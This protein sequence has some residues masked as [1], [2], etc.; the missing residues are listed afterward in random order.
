MGVMFLVFFPLPYLDA[1]SLPELLGLRILP[2]DSISRVRERVARLG[3][4]RLL[5]HLGSESLEPANATVIGELLEAGRADLLRDAACGALG[6]PGLDGQTALVVQA[7]NAL[8][9]VLAVACATAQTA[10]VV[11]RA[12][13]QVRHLRS[14]TSPL[15]LERAV[16]LQI[17]LRAGSFLR[18]PLPTV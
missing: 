18:G 4:D 1:S 6:L 2:T 17:A 10:A 12:P 15:H 9:K 8:V 5:E 13:S 11:G 14:L 16:R 3:R 7:R